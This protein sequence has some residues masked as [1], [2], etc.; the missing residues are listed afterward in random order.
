ME[1]S[2]NAL[3]VFAH[4]SKNSFNYVILQKVTELLKGKNFTVYCRDLYEINFDPVLRFGSE[5][6]YILKEQEYIRNSNFLFFIYPCWWGSMPAIMKGYID[7]VFSEGFAYK[8]VNGETLPL[9]NDKYSIVISTF[10]GKEKIYKE[11]LLE[12]SIKRINKFIIFE[13]CGIKVLEQFFIYEV[14]RKNYDL[15]I[16]KIDEVISKI[17]SIISG[18]LK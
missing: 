9:L 14:N 12:D 6:Q 5:D 15:V 4:P 13:F 16:Q 2:N 3:I 18:F 8:N 10:G 17:D 1:R 11:Y 7:R